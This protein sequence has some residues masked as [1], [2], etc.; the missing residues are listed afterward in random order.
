MTHAGSL[1]CPVTLT[2]TSD[3]GLS[4]LTVDHVYVKFGDP[5]AELV[6]EYN[7]SCGKQTDRHTQTHKCRRLG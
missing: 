7:I 6:F 2:L 5:I 4:G 3:H 1:L